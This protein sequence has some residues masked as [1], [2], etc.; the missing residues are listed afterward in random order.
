MFI[1]RYIEYL[2]RATILHGLVMAL[3]TTVAIAKDKPNILWIMTDDERPDAIGAYGASWAQTP[4]ADKLAAT[5]VRFQNAITTT[6]VCMPV[7]MSMLTGLYGHHTGLMSNRGRLKIDF[8][9]LTLQFEKAGYQVANFGKL[10]WNMKSAFPI[11][12]PK[13]AY[14]GPASSPFKLKEAFDPKKFNVINLPDFVIVSGTYP[15]PQEQTEAGLTTQQAIEFIESEV[16]EPFLLRVSYIAPHSPVLAP[17][18]YDTLI[19]PKE[20]KLQLPSQEELANKPLWEQRLRQWVGSDGKLTEQQIKQSWATYY[21]LASFVDKEMG[22]VIKALDK[23][24]LLANTIIVFI[25]DQGVEM[26]EHGFYMKRNFYDGTVKIPF[27]ISWHKM[28]PAG[29]VINEQ[30]EIIDLLPTLL[31][32]VGEP[33]PKNIDGQSAWPLIQRKTNQFREYTFSEINHL[34]SQYA[35]LN[36]DSGRRVMVRTNKWKLIFW[37]DRAE[38]DGALYNLVRD[39]GERHNLFGDFQYANI[40]NQLMQHAFAWDKGEKES[41]QKILGKN[42]ISGYD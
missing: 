21:G 40:R 12:G 32:M 3:F 24:G 29:Q 14:G 22:Q 31:D 11:R 35:H 36:I 8:R 5:G 6:P 4:V 30:V 28:I 16:Q 2:F 23:K 34:E 20:I 17:K 13:P 38:P 37:I 18:P 7:R 26:G 25:S 1:F 10:H 19:D 39:S 9:P 15:L 42:R 27:M 33:V 41:I